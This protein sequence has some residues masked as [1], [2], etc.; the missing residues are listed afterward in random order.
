MVLVGEA[1]GHDEVLLGEPFVGLSGK[2]LNK[3]LKEAGIE[4]HNLFIANTL[5]C[6]PTKNDA[7]KTN[8][9]PKAS[10]IKAC[11][12]W[13]FKQIEEIKPRVIMP[14]GLVPT[15]VLTG[16][17]T[18]ESVVGQEMQTQYG[19]VIPNWHP[20]FLMGRRRDLTSKAIDILRKAN[21]WASP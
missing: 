3:M 19:L 12:D 6:R 5:C 13:L 4:R 1:L 17:T 9:P 14:M 16:A 20:S 11:K 7:G 10:E 18:L 2:Y 21:Q 8:R 15:K